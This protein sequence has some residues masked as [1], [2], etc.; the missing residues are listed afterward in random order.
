MALWDWLIVGVYFVLS[1]VIGLRLSGRA[2]SDPAH[3]FA[4][5]RSLPWWLAGTSMVATTFAADTPLVVTGMVANHGIAGNWLW[6]SFVMSNVLTVVFFARLWRRSEVLTDAELSELRYDGRSAAALRIFRAL[7]MAL[8]INLVI[9]GWVNLA[10]VKIL[11][12]TVGLDPAVALLVMSAITLAYSVV[13]GLWGIVVTDFIQ[14]FIAMAGSI[15]LAVYALDAV[16]GLDALLAKLPGRSG[17]GQEMLALLPSG[18]SE[19]LPAATFAAYLG[20]QWWATSYPGSEP[21]GGGYIAQRIFSARTERDGVLATLWFTLAHYAIRPWPW[22]LT[23]LCVLVLYPSGSDPEAAYVKASVELLPTGARGLMIAAFAAAYMST[24]STQLNWGASYV[25]NDLYLRFWRPQA[26]GPELIRASR[27]A[28]AITYALSL[29]VTWWLSRAGSIETGWRIVVALGAGTGP[30]LI[31]RWFWWR[32]SAA[33]ELAAMAA[34]LVSFVVLTA[35]GVLDPTSPREATW[36]MLITTAIVTSAWLVTT[37]LTPPTS[38]QTL[39]RFYLRVRPGGPGWRAVR[40]RLGLPEDEPVPGG[41]ASLLAWLAGVGAVYGTLLGLGAA[42]FHE[43]ST[44]L[45]LLGGAAAAF[46][47]LGWGLS[48]QR[49]SSADARPLL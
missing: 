37:F 36:L 15:L 23:A 22:I 46:V 32:V 6:W 48:R 17:E 39:D 8:P 40:L 45:W 2:S 4:S 14:F 16:G 9:I 10:M 41:R 11:A 34:A 1:A 42:L 18:D 19:W 38:P 13:S 7:Y 3:Y 49:E 35:T 43:L 27:W 29:A 26:S 20:V 47:A 21:G 31:L 25:V 44:A 12:A 5:G 30:V 24:I 33:S 28:T